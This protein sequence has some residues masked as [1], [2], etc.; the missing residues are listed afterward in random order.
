MNL[1]KMFSKLSIMHQQLLKIT[2]ESLDALLS[3]HGKQ[4]S[5]SRIVIANLAP[6]LHL[7]PMSMY[8]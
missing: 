2:A 8:F 7:S 3:F 6:G 4:T 1:R 5:L